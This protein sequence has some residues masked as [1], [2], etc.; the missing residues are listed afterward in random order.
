MIIS[1]GSVIDCVDRRLM[2]RLESAL[3]QRQEVVVP[4]AVRVGPYVRP[5]GSAYDPDVGAAPADE[6]I[7]RIRSIVDRIDD[8]LTRPAPI[9]ATEMCNALVGLGAWL[10]VNASHLNISHYVLLRVCSS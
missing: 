1:R 8:L 3:R 9:R 5:G 4:H 7:E 10:L 6:G 2:M